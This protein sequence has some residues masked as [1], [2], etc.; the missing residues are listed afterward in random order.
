MIIALDYDDTFTADRTMWSSFVGL[1]ISAGHSV[2]FVTYRALD[3]A[4]GNEDIRSDARALGIPVV[5]SDGQQKQDV[6]SA[7]VWI[8]DSPEFIPTTL[9]RPVRKSSRK[10]KRPI[11]VMQA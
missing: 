7:D 3:R 4:E 5:Y 6:F 1:A 9:R 10:V 11:I 8:D 2:T